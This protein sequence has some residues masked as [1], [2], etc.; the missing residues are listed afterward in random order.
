MLA[1]RSFDYHGSSTADDELGKFLDGLPK[2]VIVLVAVKDEAGL[3]NGAAEKDKKGAHSQLLSLGAP[4]PVSFGWRTSWA[5]VGY[6]GPHEDVDWIRHAQALEFQG[7][8]EIVAQ[9]PKIT[10]VCM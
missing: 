7:P 5:L 3:G 6:K 9:I 1:S 10:G 4:S 8:S 2:N